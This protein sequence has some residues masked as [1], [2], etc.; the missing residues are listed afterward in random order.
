M[1]YNKYIASGLIL[2]LLIMNS[3]RDEDTLVLNP[4]AIPHGIMVCLEEITSPV[5]DVTD[6]ANSAF[7]ASLSVPS[8]N[9]D[10]YVVMAQRRSTTTSDWVEVK[11]ITDFP[12]TCDLSISASEIAAGL[13]IELTD[14]LP[15]DEI[16]FDAYA[17][18]DNGDTATWNNLDQ[19]LGTNPGQKQG[20]RYVT[21][22][23]CPF[24]AGESAGTYKMMVDDFE[25]LWDG[26]STVTVIAGP[27]ENQ[28][29]LVDIFHHPNPD[30]PGSTYDVVVDVDPLTGIAT[31]EVQIAWNY[32]NYD[33]A[34]G[35]GP[36]YIS[37]TGFVF[38]C[39]GSI[40]LS[41][42]H[43]LSW[44]SWGGGWGYAAVKQ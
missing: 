2:F 32:D 15:G 21:Y 39:T 38:S 23:S 35:Y 20:F 19:D 22:I 25:V 14:L 6:L 40:I 36:G 26:D 16:D 4:D 9:V 37:G 27:G 24:S 8:D 31:V 13:G 34:S 30:N 18:G 10:T 17:I 44:Y 43:A 12:K 7:E 29:T 42:E 3:C 41:L 1:R 33:P 11:R 5:L 28:I